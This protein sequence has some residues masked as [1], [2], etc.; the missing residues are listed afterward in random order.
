MGYS[1]T[2]GTDGVEVLRPLTVFFHGEW[3]DFACLAAGR[4]TT[5]D[6]WE[7]YGWPDEPYLA[8]CPEW[9]DAV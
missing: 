1:A 9:K 7:R 8:T 5:P 4:N 3:P 6:E 2:T